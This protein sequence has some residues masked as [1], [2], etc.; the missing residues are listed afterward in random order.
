MEHAVPQNI[1]SFQFRLVGDMTLKQF[2]FLASGC[3]LAY[4]TFLLLF[5]HNPYIAVVFILMF[6]LMGILFAFL[7]IADRPLDHWVMAFLKAV[8]SPTSGFWKNPLVKK[9]K[10]EMLENT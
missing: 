8:Y 10:T 9:N 5:S 4:L 1:T 7:P 6:T 2:G 3:A